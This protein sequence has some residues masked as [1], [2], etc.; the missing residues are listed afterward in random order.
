MPHGTVPNASNRSRCVQFIKMYPKTI[1][2]KERYN[3][4]KKAL[5]KIIAEN[6]INVS[7]IGRIV[8]GLN[9]K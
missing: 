4:R 5:T 3:E 8:F 1:I 2:S 6:N 7:T 9:E